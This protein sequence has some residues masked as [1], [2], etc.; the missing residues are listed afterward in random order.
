LKGALDN[1]PA[2]GAIARATRLNL[3][4]AD[5]LMA[6]RLPDSDHAKRAVEALRELAREQGGPWANVSLHAALQWLDFALS[7]RNWPEAV[8][9]YEHAWAADDRLVKRQLF[10]QDKTHIMAHSQGMALKGARAF[11]ERDRLKDA[12]LALERGLIPSL[13]EGDSRGG[14]PKVR[15]M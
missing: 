13:H 7:K 12:V 1:A 4:R 15:Q 8:S 2:D 9:A 6:R 3:A 11:L 5:L 14:I 10:R